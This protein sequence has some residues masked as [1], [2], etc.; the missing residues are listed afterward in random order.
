MSALSAG[1]VCVWIAASPLVAAPPAYLQP[2]A[3][4]GVAS[5]FQAALSND[6]APSLP[7]TRRYLGRHLSAGHSSADVFADPHPSVNDGGT[8]L[9]GHGPISLTQYPL[10]EPRAD[11]APDEPA[12]LPPPTMPDLNCDAAPPLLSLGETRIDATSVL[13]SG[14]SLGVT[15]VEFRSALESPRLPGASLRPIFGMH[16]LAGPTRTDLPGQVYDISLEARMYLPLGERWLTELALAPGL[17]SDFR[18]TDDAFRLVARVIAYYKHSETVRLAIGGT[19]LDREDIAWLPIG[20]V[21]WIPN[22]DWRYE[23]MFP[24]PRI[25]HR[26]WCEGQRERWIYAL[27]ELGGGS[28]SIERAGG[29][30]DI[31]TY[32]DLRLLLGVEFKQGEGHSWLLEAGYA[33]AR[34]LEYRSHLG[35]YDPDAAAIVRAALTF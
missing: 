24:R 5:P 30:A 16:M 26:F 22:E 8:L 11:R 12:I 2:P 23:L 19:Y 34:E 25:A 33:F 28:W 9:W 13:G 3:N 10:T 6:P 7:G 1:L 18:S 4:V 17:F 20:G 31:G 15:S 29:A 27:G 35:D 14:D 21:I 32:R